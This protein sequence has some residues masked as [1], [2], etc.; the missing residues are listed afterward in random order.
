[1]TGLFTATGIHLSGRLEECDPQLCGWVAGPMIGN[2]R[3]SV[4]PIPFG[5][6]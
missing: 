2:H 5:D 3:V 4:A 6:D 1:M